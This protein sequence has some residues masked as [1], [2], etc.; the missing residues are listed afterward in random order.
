M[1]ES[2]FSNIKGVVVRRSS[3]SQT[4]SPSTSSPLLV[5]Y[6]RLPYVRLCFLV[7]TPLIHIL[8][9]F[10]T[11]RGACSSSSKLCAAS[12]QLL[13]QASWPRSGLEPRC[14]PSRVSVRYA[15]PDCICL[16]KIAA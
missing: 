16:H 2:T 10:L 7:L 11:S 15:S 12:L 1:L 9:S 6:R 4:T 3:S 13:L 8:C 5:S 14:S